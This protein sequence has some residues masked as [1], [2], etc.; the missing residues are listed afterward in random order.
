MR[1]SLNAVDLEPDEGTSFGIEKHCE[2]ENLY[3]ATRIYESRA[4]TAIPAKFSMVTSDFSLGSCLQFS[5][6]KLMTDRTLT[7]IFL[8]VL[9]LLIGVLAIGFPLVI[10]GVRGWND[11]VWSYLGSLLGSFLGLLAL[12]AGAFYNAELNRVRDDRLRDEERKGLAGAL[13][14]ETA[15]I[16]K[17]TDSLQNH[18]GPGRRDPLANAVIMQTLA[19]DRSVTW[20]ANAHRVGLFDSQLAVDLS[21]F[22]SRVALFRRAVDQIKPSDDYTEIVS[23]APRLADTAESL[24]SR[25]AATAQVPPPR[26]ASASTEPDI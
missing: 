13:L 10:I 1:Y 5:H 20:E 24:I 2:A 23:V 18:F 21:E 19:P 14:A 8:G 9:A 12:L 26:F 7:P 11:G 17:Q 4:Q 22:F 16:W 3:A 15:T 25:L 6:H